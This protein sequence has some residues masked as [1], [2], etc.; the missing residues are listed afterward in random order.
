MNAADQPAGAAGHGSGKSLATGFVLAAVLTALAFAAAMPGVV[1]R[2]LAVPAM[3]A[4][5]VT[6]IV[7]HVVFFLHLN[8]KSDGGWQALAFGFTI[9]ITLILVAGSLWIM[10]HLDHNM[11]L[12]MP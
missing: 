2:T 6:Q 4:A 8:R 5:G 10:R 11:M 1:P 12:V 3:L 7:V 9:L